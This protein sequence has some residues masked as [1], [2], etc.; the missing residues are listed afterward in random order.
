MNMLQKLWRRGREL[1]PYEGF[2]FDRPIVVLQSDDWGR[3]GLRDREGLAQLAAAGLVLGERPY[4]FYTL[5]TADDLAALRAVLRG[6]HDSAGRSPGLEMN[7]VVANLDFEKMDFENLDIEKMSGEG[8]RQIRL[9]ALAE[10]LPAGWNRPGLLEAY[11]EGIREGLFCPALHGTTH[12]CRAAVERSLIESDLT[13]SREREK[14]L[15]TLWKAGTPYIYWRMPWIGYE[16]WD[17]G[18]SPNEEFLPAETQTDLIGKA[19]GDFAK[20]F[21]TLPR[22]ACAPGYRA[23]DDTHRAWAQIGIRVAQNGPG[24]ATPPHFDRH[25]ILQLHRAVEFEPAVN[26][27]FSL[28]PCICSAEACFE[29]NI[30]AIVSV[31]SINFHSSVKDFRSRTLELLDQFLAALESAH[32]DVLY[33][34]GEE[35]YEIVQ[36]GTR[37]TAQGTVSI[38]VTRKSFTK[39]RVPPVQET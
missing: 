28:E 26:P 30:P 15:R 17:P 27:D 37:E 10:G 39:S 20:L 8:V 35:L 9:R 36:N 11:R 32:P 4:D 38:N 21:S 31:H 6:H 22:S 14:L 25:G 5:E 33:L 29:R 34:H 18:A 16:Y 24:A 23:N 1:F 3:A 19:V 2:H 12:F 13:S 7:F